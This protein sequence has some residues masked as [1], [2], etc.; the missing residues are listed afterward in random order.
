[1]ITTA[2]LNALPPEEAN[3]WFMQICTAPRWCKMMVESM[4]F[5][6]MSSIVEQAKA[7]WSDMQEEDFLEAFQGHPMIG[8]INTLRE[9]FAATKALAS[10]EQAGTANADEST[11]NALHEANHKYLDKN[12]FIF[13][14]CASGLSAETMLAAL[15]ERLKNNRVEEV[16]IAANEQLKISL[17]RI[18]KAISE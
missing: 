10:N 17:L 14:I 9:K 18:E 15:Q 13:I 8:D 2:E 6:S 1:M 16:G 4:P 5:A 7:H 3:T 12:G 11:L